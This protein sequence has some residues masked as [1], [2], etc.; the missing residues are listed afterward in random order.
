MIDY[1][2]DLSQFRE[3]LCLHF[4][5]YFIEVKTTIR[6]PSSNDYR[7]TNVNLYKSIEK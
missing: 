1:M 7:L 6:D 5:K 4:G 3:T 2:H